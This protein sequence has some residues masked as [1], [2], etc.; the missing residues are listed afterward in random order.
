MPKKQW[1]PN[2]TYPVH[3]AVSLIILQVFCYDWDFSVLG[4]ETTHVSCIAFT[5]HTSSVSFILEQSSTPSPS[6]KYRWWKAGPVEL[7]KVLQSEYLSVSSWYC[8]ICSSILNISCNLE[9]KSWLDWVNSFFWSRILRRWWYTLHCNVY[10]SIWIIVSSL[11]IFINF[12][13]TFV[14]LGTKVKQFSRKDR[15]EHQFSL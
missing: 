13:Y 11:N 2:I 14:P 8:F 10:I 4:W 1:F 3:V 12:R 6:F 9:V 5:W 15:E 7:S